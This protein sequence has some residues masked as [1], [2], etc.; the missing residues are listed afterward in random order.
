M[1]NGGGIEFL[2][3]ERGTNSSRRRGVRVSATH[4]LVEGMV[5][6]ASLAR[7]RSPSFQRDAEDKE[8]R[9]RELDFKSLNEYI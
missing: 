5:K 7:F 8:K 4:R 6:E 9:E 1:L 2:D 3:I